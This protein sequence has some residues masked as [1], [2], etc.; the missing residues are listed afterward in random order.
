M[1]LTN[2]QAKQQYRYL[3]YLII[4]S[5]VL[6]KTGGTLYNVQYLHV[7]FHGVLPKFLSSY[8]MYCLIWLLLQYQK[9]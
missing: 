6:C 5:C 9:S 8:F 4:I 3:L 2:I 7:V 1:V